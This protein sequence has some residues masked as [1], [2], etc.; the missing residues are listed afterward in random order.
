MVAGHEAASADELVALAF[1]FDRELFTGIPGETPLERAARLDV[2]A[3]VLAD[4]DPEAARFAR[5][6]LRSAPVPL[7]RTVPVRCRTHRTGV[8]A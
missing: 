5:E 3:E 7:R 6:L 4:L 2:A 8:A 1:G